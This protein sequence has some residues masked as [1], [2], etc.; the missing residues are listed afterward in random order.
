[1]QFSRTV[2]P[3]TSK[4]PALI[5]FM[6]RNLWSKAGI[7]TSTVPSWA[8]SGL[9][10]AK[11]L[12]DARI[13]V[14]QPATFQPGEF[15]IGVLSEMKR[16]GFRIWMLLAFDTDTET[17]ASCAAQEGMDNAFA[18]IVPEERSASLP[19]QGWIFLRPLIP[20]EGVQAFAEQVSDYTNS[21]FNFTLAADSVDLTFSIA[22][23]EAIML[24]AHAATQL[25]SEGGNLNDGQAVTSKL[26]STEFAGVGGKMVALN[27]QGD[28]ID[29]YE[30]MNYV[31]GA[32]GKMD[33]L[34]VGM[35]NSTLEQ[36]MAYE[37]AVVWP[38]NTT[39]VPLDYV[40]GAVLFSVRISSRSIML[41]ACKIFKIHLDFD[42]SRI[43][44]VRQTI[45]FT[46]L[47][48]FQS[49]DPGV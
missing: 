35:Y 20:A 40:S 41:Y 22:L 17:V 7:L 38:G 31:V 2:A 13:K 45:P 29:V 3:D 33:R 24:Y 21:H 36:Y 43:R 1:M 34:P 19:M 15:K 48:S 47:Y 23:Y 12:Q 16:T 46:L 26:R 39:E 6:R 32:D 8:D 4:G 37:R 25:L 49:Q 30:V 28:R 11:Q 42:V 5:A 18:W 44:F 14:H 27:E 9:G 10:L